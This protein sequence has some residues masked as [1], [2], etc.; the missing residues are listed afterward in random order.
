MRPLPA[1]APLRTSQGADLTVD[2]HHSHPELSSRK[3]TNRAHVHPYA[4]APQHHVITNATTPIAEVPVRPATVTPPLTPTD[5]H[6]FFSGSTDSQ[7]DSALMP[8]SSFFADQVG[9]ATPLQSP[10]PISW[11]S[12]REAQAFTFPSTSIDGFPADSF[13]FSFN[14]CATPSPQEYVGYTEM[15][16]MMSDHAL[17]AEL[18]LLGDPLPMS[19]ILA[20][21]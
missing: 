20:S 21:F 10:S 1:L 14:M 3:F 11:L 8:V 9:L 6:C 7:F 18:E 17:L 15:P 13:M 5:G 4:A 2:R 19:S 12:T 16:Q